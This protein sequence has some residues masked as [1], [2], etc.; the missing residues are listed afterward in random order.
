M[1]N[2]DNQNTKRRMIPYEIDFNKI[3][4]EDPNSKALVLVNDA[5]YHPTTK[6]SQLWVILLRSTGPFF[7]SS[8]SSTKRSTTEGTYCQAARRN[9]GRST[10]AQ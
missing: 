8:A 4:A 5:R 10:E 1:A 7:T 2:Q 3:L 9:Q 6:A